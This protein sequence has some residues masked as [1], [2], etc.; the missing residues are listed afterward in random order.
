MHTT[1]EAMSD[2]AHDFERRKMLRVIRLLMRDLNTSERHYDRFEMDNVEC[3]LLL[4]DEH[5]NVTVR[6]DS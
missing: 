5:G 2:R 1:E 6:T 3:G 4:E